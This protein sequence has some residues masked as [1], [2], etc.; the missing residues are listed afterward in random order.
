ME[1]QKELGGGSKG[2]SST[3]STN[4]TDSMTAHDLTQPTR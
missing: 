4:D 1:K 3:D 2:R